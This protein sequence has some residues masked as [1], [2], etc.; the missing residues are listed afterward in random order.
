VTFLA[1]ITV[2]LTP[3]GVNF[4]NMDVLKYPNGFTLA[5]SGML[6]LAAGLAAIFKIKKWW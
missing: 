3:I 5:I 4:T 2:I 1:V 6:L